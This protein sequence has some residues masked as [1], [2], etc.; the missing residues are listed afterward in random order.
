MPSILQKAPSTITAAGFTLAILRRILNIF[1]SEAGITVLAKMKVKIPSNSV[2]IIRL[3][4]A[5]GSETPEA[6]IAANSYFSAKL[7]KVSIAD[8]STVRG[9]TFS[10]KLGIR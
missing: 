4:I 6:F 10:V 7:P 3:R 5:F 1:C 9:S 2:N 8:R